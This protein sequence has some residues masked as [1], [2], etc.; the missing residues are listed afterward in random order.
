V[1]LFESVKGKLQ[2]WE[3][4]AQH[5]ILIATLRGVARVNLSALVTE[6]PDRAQSYKIAL[7]ALRER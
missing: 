1:D 4:A 2:E 7:D 6:D 5:R 3:A